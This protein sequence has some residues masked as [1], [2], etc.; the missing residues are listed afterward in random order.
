[1]RSDW[2]RADRWGEI[3]VRWGIGR[4]RY[5]VE[6]GLYA[7]GDPTPASPVFVSANYKLSFDHLRRALAGI[8]GWILVL[9]TRGV[10]VW[11]AAGKGTFGTAELLERVRAT[12][13]EEVVSH[14]ELI[15]P[16]L[17]ATGIAAHRVREASGFRVIYGPVRARDIAAF[18]AA[19]KRATPE[20]RRVR[21]DLRDRLA[22]VPVELRE[23]GQYA[24]PSAVVLFALS[25]LHRGGFSG[26]SLIGSGPRAAVLIL[27]ALLSGAVLTPL[28]LP[29]LPGRAFTVKGA[30]LGAMVAVGAIA[31][32]GVPVHALHHRVDAAGWLLMLPAIS[33][34]VA[35]NYTGASTFTSLSGVK[36]EMRY[37]IP[38]LI[39]AAAAGLAL[40]LLAR[41]LG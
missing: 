9:D 12:R 29:W 30:T 4:M 22:V 7:I 20:M 41:F 13:L 16:Q 28:L 32:D 37:A 11:C 2:T 25:G 39:I 27:S 23:W 1:V 40:W 6:P 8:D 35:M 10:N 34:F 26:A 14:R 19:G 18:L 24:V 38:A 5:T 17:G 36:R 15:V 31:L 33:G 21:F 3:R